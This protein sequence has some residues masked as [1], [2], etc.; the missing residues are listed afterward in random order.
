MKLYRMDYND[1]RRRYSVAKRSVVSPISTDVFSNY[2]QTLFKWYYAMLR[3]F[4]DQFSLLAMIIF[5]IAYLDYVMA[6]PIFT[7]QNPVLVE[8]FNI[9]LMAAI[10]LS[11]GV[12]LSAILIS[13]AR[14]FIFLKNWL[15]RSWKIHTPP[16][17]ETSSPREDM[18][19]R[20]LTGVDSKISVLKWRARV[21]VVLVL[22]GLYISYQVVPGTVTWI[23]NSWPTQSLIYVLESLPLVGFLVEL[24][25]NTDNIS[26]EE[27]TYIILLFGIIGGSYSFA[28]RNKMYVYEIKAEKMISHFQQKGLLRKWKYIIEV[29]GGTI[30]MIGFFI[31]LSNTL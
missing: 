10:L 30:L 4:F 20:S 19:P 21:V 2:S 29:F 24:L 14:L 18:A 17:R 8:F 3:I 12:F 26:K 5:S 27:A 28:L 1:I 22:S 7:S 11:T 13:Y 31:W 6:Y 16:Y 25:T 15:I 23:I 9:V